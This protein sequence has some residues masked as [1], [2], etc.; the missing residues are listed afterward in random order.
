MRPVPTP[1]PKRRTKLVAHNLLSGREELIVEAGLAKKPAGQSLAEFRETLADGLR[2]QFK[3]RAAPRW[4]DRDGTPPRSATPTVTASVPD[5]AGGSER[6]RFR[7]ALVDADAEHF[8]VLHFRISAAAEKDH[9]AYESA[10]ENII[11][12]V[13]AAKHEGKPIR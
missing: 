7:L 11:D 9:R 8:A 1:E 5:G 4:Q 13:V 6:L 12:S 2:R 10:V 3:L